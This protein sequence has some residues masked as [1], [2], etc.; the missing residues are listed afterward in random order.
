MRRKKQ[1]DVFNISFLDLLSGALGAVII[2]FI[3]VPKNEAPESS[4]K[5]VKAL[6]TKENKLINKCLDHIK[7]K[8]T[9]ISEGKLAQKQL[10]EEIAKLQ[11]ALAKAKPTPSKTESKKSGTADVG[12]DFKGKNVVFLIDVSGSM[13]G[14]KLGQVKAGLKMLIASMG[15]DYKVDI[16]YFPHSPTQ[17][18]YALWGQIQSMSSM[19]VKNE[20]YD[21]LARLRPRGSTPTRS[22]LIYTLQQYPELTDVVLLSDGT[23]TVSGSR[24]RDNYKGLIEDINQRNSRDIQINTIGVGQSRFSSGSSLYKFLRGL[25]EKSKGFYYGF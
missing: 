12:F 24:K 2:L 4:E 25:S 15:E 19:T 3:S 18:Y 23:P 21:F 10:K 1:I 6:C 11:Q 14:E 20:V 5:V 8:D 9:E 22:A 13:A 16:V 7:K 17:D